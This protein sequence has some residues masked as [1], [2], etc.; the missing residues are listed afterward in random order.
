MELHSLSCTTELSL[1]VAV[2]NMHQFALEKHKLVSRLGIRY[3]L[4]RCCMP[5]QISSR[6]QTIHSSKLLGVWCFLSVYNQIIQLTLGT[7][8]SGKPMC[9][10]NLLYLQSPYWTIP[11]ISPM[12]MAPNQQEP[13]ILPRFHFKS[14]GRI[15]MY[16][17]ECTF[18]PWL[19]SSLDW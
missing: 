9:K 10:T 17:L 15:W 14:V 1:M 16:G 11:K 12:Y 5:L 6:T 19:C 3:L 18:I 2:E 13:L 4:Y 7:A 8:N